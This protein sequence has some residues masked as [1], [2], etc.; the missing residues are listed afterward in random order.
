MMQRIKI[1]NKSTSKLNIMFNFL[2]II[3]LNFI[4]RAFIR[5]LINDQI[6]LNFIKMLIFS[7]R[8]LR[9]VYI[10]TEKFRRIKKKFQKFKNEQTKQ[11]KL[12]FLKNVIQRNIISIQ[13]QT[14]K[15]SY[16]KK[17]QFYFFRSDD[18]HRTNND[19]FF[20]ANMRFV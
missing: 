15:T 9:D 17:N 14:L 8:F 16:Y 20:H 2:K 10:L 18:R 13:I 11:K 6:K 4:I 5:D 12:N 1:K 7:E 19:F 3:I